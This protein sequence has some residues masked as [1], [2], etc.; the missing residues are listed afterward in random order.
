MALSFPKKVDFY[1]RLFYYKYVTI[2][3]VLYY[4]DTGMQTEEAEELTQHRP[5]RRHTASF[6]EKRSVNDDWW[7]IVAE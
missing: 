1:R 5:W 6:S 3:R 2:V 7:L 4:I